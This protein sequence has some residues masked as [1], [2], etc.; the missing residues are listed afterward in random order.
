MKNIWI[1]GSS[2][3]V[4]VGTELGK[5]IGDQQIKLLLKSACWLVQIFLQHTL[6]N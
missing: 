2:H 6:H 4:K 3:G 5:V 1:V